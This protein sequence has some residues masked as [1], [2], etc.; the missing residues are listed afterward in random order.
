MP[1][2]KFL[3]IASIAVAIVAAIATAP[4]AR[5]D[6]KGRLSD[7]H[8]VN[9]SAHKQAY[10]GDKAGRRHARRERREARQ[11]RHQ[12][13]AE[14]RN[15][16]REARHER[17]QEH[18]QT[19]NHGYSVAYGFA[20]YGGVRYPARRAYRGYGAASYADN[21]YR[22]CRTVSKMGYDAYGN[23]ARIGGT[24]CFDGYGQGHIVPGSRYI[25]EVYE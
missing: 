9:N 24:M 8:K 3:L 12:A 6:T 21:G 15:E 14:A 23:A 16:R 1:Q 2:R 25:I 22:S 10:R 5:A 11:E 4:V 18:R 17:R 19:E 20:A 7:T 13:R